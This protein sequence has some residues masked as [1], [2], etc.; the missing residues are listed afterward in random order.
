[1]AATKLT[2]EQRDL[3]LQ[4]LAAEYDTPTIK[5]LL[6]Q[7]ETD[8]NGNPTGP[9][10]SRQAIHEYRKRHGRRISKLRAQRR[11]SALERGVANQA[12][13]IARLI[14]HADALERIKWVPDDNGRLWNE[15][16]WRE[17]L[18]QV[19]KEKGELVERHDHRGSI[20]VIAV[21]YREAAAGLA[22]ASPE[23]GPVED[24]QP[25]G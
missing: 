22:P 12:E 13:R 8:A 3:V 4:L 23:A 7:T 10:I 2:D 20:E 25:P 5:Y 9:D 6:R 14:E 1:M 11:D 18:Q 15:K 21:D 19:A 24:S 17:C 16:A